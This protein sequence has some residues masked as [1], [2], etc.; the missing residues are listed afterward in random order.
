MKRTL[1]IFAALTALS[2][3]SA[4][5][6]DKASETFLKKAIEGNYAEVNMGELAQKNGQSDGVKS[7]GKMLSTDHAA[8]NQKAMDAAKTMGMNPPS[9]P[10]AKEK[11]EYKKM[12]KL[13]G[14]KF[15]KMFARH[16]VKDHEKDIA[17]YKKESK[18][19]DAAG[20]YASSQ[21]DTLQKHLDAAKSLES[22]K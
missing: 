21:I 7:F 13:S 20:E 6:K 22:G 18:T 4:T 17:D 9:G 11:D 10:N 14:E 15:D 19:K 8:G 1:V 12:S 2:I 5:A 16:M 3:S